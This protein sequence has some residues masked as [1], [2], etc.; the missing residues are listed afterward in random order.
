MR[1]LALGLVASSAG[2]ARY[3]LAI[4]GGGWLAR[5]ARIASIVAMKDRAS[6]EYGAV[7]IT[8]S[9]DALC[10]TTAASSFG[11]YRIRRSCVTAVH[12]L[13]AVSR[14]QTSSGQFGG[15]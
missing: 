10:L 11:L 3:T 7:P 4:I 8:T 5:N 14:S 13:I 6:S 9:S 15:K 2:D 1:P 12:P